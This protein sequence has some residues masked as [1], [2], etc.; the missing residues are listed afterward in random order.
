MPKALR[1]EL[2]IRPGDEVDVERQGDG[3]LVRRARPESRLYRR[4]AD[5]GHDLLADLRV[6]R[7]LEVAREARR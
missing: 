4:L 1:D 5:P 6:E 2:R 7:N 3:L